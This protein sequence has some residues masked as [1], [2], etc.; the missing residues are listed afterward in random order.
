MAEM[1]TDQANFKGISEEPVLIPPLHVH[2][3]AQKVFIEVDEKGTE[4]A[5]I[6][7]E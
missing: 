2:G 7:C 1:F 4:A 6:S 5:A 3:I